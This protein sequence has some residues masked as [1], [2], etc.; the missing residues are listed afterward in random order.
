M[1]GLGGDLPKEAAHLK[2]EPGW[3]GV[4]DEASPRGGKKGVCG[5]TDKADDAGV[6]VER[7]GGEAWRSELVSELMGM[8]E[9]MKRVPMVD[10]K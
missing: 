2:S 3:V 7:P 6:V 1:A 9:V 8:G 10:E 5:E 4:A